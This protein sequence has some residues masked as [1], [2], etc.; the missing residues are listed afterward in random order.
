V[1]VLNNNDE[2]MRKK[3]PRE[4]NIATIRDKKEKKTCLRCNITITNRAAA[5]ADSCAKSRTDR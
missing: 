2:S 1:R 4:E 3:N 5:I